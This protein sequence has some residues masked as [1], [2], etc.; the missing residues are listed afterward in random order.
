[1]SV[2]SAE[3]RAQQVRRL[4]VALAIPVLL[5]LAAA[6]VERGIEQRRTAHQVELLRQEVQRLRERNVELQRELEYRRSD[7]YI[8]KVA[9]EELHLAKPG[10]HTVI[11]V[12]PTPT[13]TPAPSPDERPPEPR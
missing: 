5:Y 7:A 13:I 6:T 4:L 12:F 8:E 1:M 10:E 9:R 2:D 11:L 3:R